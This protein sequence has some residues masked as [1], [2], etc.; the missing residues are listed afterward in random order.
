MRALYGSVEKWATTHRPL[1]LLSLVA[2]GLY[3]VGTRVPVPGVSTEALPLLTQGTPATGLALY[4]LFTGGNF[5]RVTIFALGIMPYITTLVIAYVLTALGLVRG[6]GG[7]SRRAFAW[8]GCALVLS[9]VQAMAIAI[10][11]ER[12]TAMPGAPTLVAEPGWGF[13]LTLVASV[14]TAT[15]CLIWL[16]DEITRRGIGRGVSLVFFAG[17]VVGLPGAMSATLEHVRAGH[18]GSGDLAVLVVGLVASSALVLLVDPARWSHLPSHGRDAGRMRHGPVLALS[19]ALAVVLTGSALQAQQFEIRAATIESTD[20]WQRME[21]PGGQGPIWVSPTT[22]LTGADIERAQE[23][24]DA[25][26]RLAVSIEL[27]DAGAE[28]MRQLSTAQLGK[29]VAMVLGG[30]LIWAP[31]MR[32]EISNEAMITGGGVNGLTQDEVEQILVSVN[33]Q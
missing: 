24:R 11:L 22:S 12:V 10:F 32:A 23:N 15:A 26:G 14:T 19:C 33:N 2:I 16:S 21:R 30:R 31:T 1:A 28:K 9:V 7:G 3:W 8:H 25:D 5:R 27:T 6:W 13:R 18:I 29:P 4:D 20:G 17:L